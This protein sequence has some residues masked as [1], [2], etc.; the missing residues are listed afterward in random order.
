M[1]PAGSK[2]AGEDRDS[3]DVG[4]AW[5]C[6]SDELPPEE[7]LSPADHGIQGITGPIKLGPTHGVSADELCGD[8]WELSATNGSSE[9][10][11]DGQ[12]DQNEATTVSEYYQ[13]GKMS[14]T[15]DQDG[16]TWGNKVSA[17]GTAIDTRQRPDSDDNTLSDAGWLS[18][19]R[20]KSKML[21]DVGSWMEGGQLVYGKDQKRCCRPKPRR[22]S[23]PPPDAQCDEN[24]G[25]CTD[26]GITGTRPGFPAHVNSSHRSHSPDSL[27]EWYLHPT[28]GPRPGSQEWGMGPLAG[29]DLKNGQHPGSEKHNLAESN[30]HW[31]KAKNNDCGEYD[32]KEAACKHR[33]EQVPET[34][35][36]PGDPWRAISCKWGGGDW[37]NRCFSKKDLSN[38]KIFE[39]DQT[40]FSGC[41][42]FDSE[43]K[44]P[45]PCGDYYHK[46]GAG[47]P[48]EKNIDIVSPKAHDTAV[49]SSTHAAT[50]FNQATF[51][52]Y[53]T[54]GDQLTWNGSSNRPAGYP[55]YEGIPITEDDHWAYVAP[56]TLRGEKAS[57]KVLRVRGSMGRHNANETLEPQPHQEPGAADVACTAPAGLPVPAPFVTA[58]SGLGGC[59]PDVFN[60]YPSSIADDAPVRQAGGHIA[61]MGSGVW[62][63]HKSPIIN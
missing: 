37:G 62:I 16:I 12:G 58:S 20:N 26:G 63:G 23:A 61:G 13:N 56:I 24:T 38:A 31:Y 50:N 33:Y 3:D 45:V 43:G 21:C 2:E 15:R 14:S 44:R 42:C 6:P 28:A 25:K 32:G 18:P 9:C 29:I 1:G 59:V 27:M 55:D 52:G 30:C 60:D 47:V 39:I 19:D 40:D 11:G 8:G 48:K 57:T 41:N 34:L 36:S 7:R 46:Q 22:S 35:A 4:G 5:R 51:I 54:H 53:S 17:G 49:S 10:Y